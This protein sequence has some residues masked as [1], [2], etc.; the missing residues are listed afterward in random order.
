MAPSVITINPGYV[1]A[2]T[3][4]CPLHATSATGE[5]VCWALNHRR[6][7]S[8]DPKHSPRCHLQSSSAHGLLSVGAHMA[9][10]TTHGATS[11]SLD[12]AI[13]QAVGAPILR[14]NQL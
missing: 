3:C 7:P 14:D 13:T 8:L 6:D 11:P 5:G 10:G 9:A 2:V 12:E 1:H 4:G